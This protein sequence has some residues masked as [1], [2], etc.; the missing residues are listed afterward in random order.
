VATARTTLSS[1]PTTLPASFAQQRLWFLDQFEGAGAVYNVPFATRLRGQLDVAALKRALNVLAERHESLRT[2]FTL[3]GDVPHQLIRSPEPLPLKLIDLRGAPGAE[4]RGLEVVVE[5]AREPFDLC[6]G[7]LARALLVK[8]GEEDHILSLT[9][10]HIITDAWSMG[11]LNR[12]LSTLYAGFLEGR[13]VQLPELPIQYADYAVWQQRW[14]QSGGLDQQLA[15]W[16][17]QLAGA[18]ALLQ[19]PSDQPRPA[20]QSFN[21]ATVSLLLAQETLARVRALGQREGA[22]LFMTL[23]AAFAVLLSRY[24]GQEDLVIASP[25]ANRGRVELEGVIGFLVNTLALRIDV[26]GEPSFSELVRRVREVVLGAF[27]NQDLP[28]EKLVEELNPD[29]H[30][31]HAPVAQVLFVLGTGPSPLELPG[32]TTG[33]L[34][35]QRGTAKF[36]LSFFAAE[37]SE[38]LRL[39]L[40][41]CTDLFEEATAVR[42]LEHYGVLLEAALADPARPVGQ[43]SCS[44]EA[45]R[46]LVGSWNQTAKRYPSES[47]RPVHELVSE[48]ARRSP[49][50]T[51]VACGEE[52]LSYAQ[53]EARANQ[54]GRCLADLGVGPGVVAAI[55]AER[56]LEMVIAVL[57]VLRA[58]GAYAPIDPAYPQERVAFMLADAEAP[59]LLTQQQLLA[60]L[61]AHRARSVCLDADREEINRYDEGPVANTATPEDLAYVIYTSGSTGRPKGVAMGHRP[62]SNLLAW[63]LESFAAPAAA[64]TLQFASLSFDVAF[65][66][67][68]STWCSGGTLVLIDEAVRRDHEALL[69]LIREQRVERLFL[70]F[71]AL[72]NLCEAASHLGA[73]APS[74]REVITAGEQ[75]KITEAI[76]GFFAAHAGCVLVNQYG[77]TES[78]VVSAFGLSGAAERWPALPP[79]GRPIANARLHLLDRHRQ[80]VPIGVPGELHIGGVSLARGYLNRAEL[81]DERFVAD[82]FSAHPDARLYRT[83]D[84]ARH[85]PDG[86]ID[87]IGRSDH[88]IK[89]RGFRI[90]PGEIEAALRGHAAVSQALVVA[91][92]DDAGAKRLVAYMTSDGAPDPS[93]QELNEL[94]RRTLPDYMIPSAFV[95]LDAFPLSPNGKLDRAALPAP[96]PRGSQSSEHVA[97]RTAT[98]RQL[99]EI[100][101]KL[102]EI[103]DISVNE[104]FFALGGHSLMA[105]RLVVRIRESLGVEVPVRT[106]FET[107]TLVALAAAVDEVASGP[108]AGAPLPPIA[109][110]ARERVQLDLPDGRYERCVLPASFAEQRLWFLDQLEPNSTAYNVPL[111]VRLLGELDIA[112]ME[113]TLTALQARHESLRTSFALIDGEPKQVIMAPSA[114]SLQ[115]RDLSSLQDAEEQAQRLVREESRQPFELATGVMRAGLVRIAADEHILLLTLHHI[116]T[117]AW[118]IGVLNRE[119]STLYAGFLEGREVQL[120]E[121]PIQYADY[122]VWQQRWMQ[123]GGLDQQLAYWKEQ[124]AGAPALLQLPSDQPRPA[125]QSFN[126][127][128]V[129]L[130]LAQETLARVRALG[131]REGATLFMTL[132]AA[133]AVLLSRYS[134]QE[135]LVIASPV[136]NRGRVELEG[137]IGFLVNTLALRIDVEG[138]PSFSELVRRVREV[139]LGAFANQ[140]LPFEKLVEELNPDRHLSHAPVAQVLFVLGTGP[141]P[142]ELPG[143]TTGRL[144]QQRGTAK[145]D[146]SFFAAETSEGLRLALEYCTDL[147]EEATAVR[148]LEHYGVL[149]EAALADP[150]RPV[151]Q[152]SC[153]SEAERAL[154]GS[155]NQTAKRYPSESVRPVHELV[156][157]QARRSP[158]ATAVACGEEQLSYAQLEARANQLGRCLAD[159]GVGPGVVAA[160]CAERSLEMVIAVLA[161]L[162]AGGA[163]APID[164]AYPQERVAFMLA[165]AEAPVLL[166]Q[167]QLLAGLPA[168][169]ARSVCL[170]ADREEINRYDEGPVA[171]TATPEDLAYVIYTSGSTGRPKGVAMGHRPLSNLLAW[172]LESFAAPAAA[173]TLQFASLSFDVA[174]QEIFSTWC[175]GGTL[176]LIDEAVRRDHEALLSLIREQRVERLFLP[177]AALQNLCEA[178]SHLGATAPSLREV[179]TAG[180][181]LKITE[182]IRGFFAAH[183]GCVLVNQYGPTES[184]VVSAFGLSGAAERWPALPPIGRPIANARLHLLDR[185]RQPVPIGVPG[186]LHIGGVSLARGYLNRA[187]LTDER[188]VADPFSA[189]P[190]ARLYRTGDLARHLP[191]GNIDYIGRSDHQIKV[192]GFRIEPG[193]IEAALRGHAAVSQALVVAREDD[194]GAKRL[195][196]YMTSDGAPDPSSQELNELLRRTL[197]DYMIPSAFVFLDAFPLSPNGKLDRAALPAPSPRGSQSS[198]HVAPRT[199]TERQLAEIWSKL[200][201]IEDISVNENFFALGGHSLM[202]VRL[203]AQMERKLGVRLPLSALFQSATIAGLAGLVEVE[204]DI[205]TGEWPSLVEL[206]PGNSQPPLFLLSW[207]D[208]EVL[209]WREL[210]ENLDSGMPIFGLRPPG[211]DGAATPL[212]SVE[213]LAAHYIQTV[214]GVQPHGP[215]RLGGFCFS[216]LVAYEMARLLRDQGEDL[217]LLALIDSYPSRLARAQRAFGPTRRRLATLRDADLRGKIGLVAKHV[218]RLPGNVRYAAYERIG[219]RLFELLEARGLQRLIPRW[220]LNPVYVA[221]NLARQRYVPQPADVRVEF[222][223]AQSAPDSRPTPWE[224]LAN[225]GVGLRQIVATDLNHER[226]MREPHVRLVAAELERA[227]GESVD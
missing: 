163:Y 52:Q 88:Q 129:S 181:Q 104:N 136:A 9:L 23:L 18:P 188:F 171:N 161:V 33:R 182:A 74:L 133:F 36:D 79:I 47:V 223:R 200:L 6:A 159:L 174:F 102:L 56:S 81:T 191:D 60:G 80:P 14:M 210:V 46:A 209:P 53:L 214:R 162:R 178:A 113:R 45:E 170:D 226:M 221:S 146:L 201:E 32:L 147:F 167:Q 72:Q 145:F 160:I 199:A 10:H 84:L 48:Q 107:R 155:W 5:Q 58:G 111:A 95:F 13:E 98:E 3:V 17:E 142:L 138:E 153:S 92:E 42:M 141:S 192:R 117:D 156:S 134:G 76:R 62:L 26:E 183:A 73:T 43:L 126:G 54:L 15:Y 50:A 130:L 164:P 27:A 213:Q 144:V 19:L 68:F 66:E 28:F 169:R 34:V 197:P 112:A 30:L 2:T 131:Q 61:P 8:L 75:L 165:D 211:V 59:V 35:Q 91:R 51:A 118:S 143:L 203:F 157:E 184:H 195:V 212:A 148:M 225:R 63:Q 109:A 82:P 29:R 151:G 55:C 85:L 41:Y 168:H 152:L 115:L 94:L 7:D 37:T 25:V 21:G 100:W 93:S 175:S 218:M 83:G 12:E 205:E 65:Q 189:H 114:V 154:V 78:H 193:E 116:I 180:E 216:G 190:D 198:E 101:S 166:T 140:D 67:I 24:S 127:A 208:G 224:A 186:E 87:Y 20:M 96:S 217:A 139:V 64:R 124:L 204:R 135:D 207:A 149:L 137:V 86:N 206:R 150:A 90:E 179:I 177:F 120:P 38:G 31:S 119:L 125:M 176:V 89:V 122:A 110:V 187:E 44:S 222:F 185:H 196:A 97:P 4:R 1:A 173:R 123:S 77:P 70:P 57:A 40:E 105:T 99:A 202:A 103:E 22:T 69:S 128:T 158:D 219:P 215:Y 106:V 194:A 220:P 121:L 16:K 108:Q 132:L 172:Q 11:V 71:A 49:D 227:L 39:A